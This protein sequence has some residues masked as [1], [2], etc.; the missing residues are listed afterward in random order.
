MK[1]TITTKGSLSR[2]YAVNKDNKAF[3]F[4]L[5]DDDYFAKVVN[6]QARN[7]GERVSAEDVKFSLDRARDKSLCLTIILTICT[8]I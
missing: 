6:G 4:L 1:M 5:R 2:D 8:N 3:Y 7:T